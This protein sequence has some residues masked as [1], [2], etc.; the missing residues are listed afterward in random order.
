MVKNN[1]EMSPDQQYADLVRIVEQ[2]VR[3][4]VELNTTVFPR[5]ITRTIFSRYDEGMAYGTHVD[6][7]VIGFMQPGQRLRSLRPELPPYRLL[8]DGLPLRARHATAAVS[9]RS[10]ARGVTGDTS[11]FPDARS[12]TR[13]AFPTRSCR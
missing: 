7:A 12:S 10:R 13:P 3:A 11:C 9:C 6:S 8:H 1:L 5:T 2:A 4:N